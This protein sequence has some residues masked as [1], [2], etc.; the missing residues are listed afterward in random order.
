MPVHRSAHRRRSTWSEQPSEH[1]VLSCCLAKHPNDVLVCER[2]VLFDRGPPDS[3]LAACRQLTE[4]C[5]CAGVTV[6]LQRISSWRTCADAT[7]AWQ[8]V[9]QWVAVSED[10][11]LEAL[12]ILPGVLLTKLRAAYACQHTSRACRHHTAMCFAPSRKSCGNDGSLRCHIAQRP[13][14]SQKQLCCRGKY[15]VLPPN[16]DHAAH[17][18]APARSRSCR[19]LRGPYSG[20]DRQIDQ[21]TDHCSD[22]C[23]LYLLTPSMFVSGFRAGK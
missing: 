8:Q 12:R 3:M 17:P 22:Q 21:W 4:T 20:I 7:I 9:S 23:Y 10:G 15:A 16:A 14:R 18:V 6:T 2:E 5:F 13:Q 11:I 19:M 1:T